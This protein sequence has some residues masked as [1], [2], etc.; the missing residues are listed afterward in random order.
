MIMN[1][2]QKKFGFTLVEILVAIS[3]L[4][5]SILATFTAVQGALRSTN[6]SEDQIIAYY[7]ADEALE[8]V[9]N[10]RDSN[11]IQ[12]INALGSGSTYNWLTDIS[13]VCSTAC[14]VD[15]PNNTITACSSNASSCPLLLYNTNTGLYQYVSGNNTVYRRALSVTAVNATEVSVDVSV[16]WT[17]QGISKVHTQKLVLRNWTE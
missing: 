10:K 6:F 16:S 2:Y 15:I 11:G 17:A 5:I 14:Y 13:P 4:S 12:H 8:Y 9:R 1:R 3:I 7:L